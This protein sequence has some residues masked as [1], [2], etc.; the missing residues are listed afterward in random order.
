MVATAEV[1]REMGVH[2]SG[3]GE[4][5]GR[6]WADG[7]L[8]SAK[9]EYGRTVYSNANDYGPVQGGR[10]EAGGTGRDAVVGTGGTLPGRDKGDGGGGG[11]R[12][13]WAGE[14]KEGG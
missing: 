5:G 10:E 3:G 9:A 14:V 4:R 12:Q 6:V 7:N 8:H 13:G 1:G 11:G 2:L